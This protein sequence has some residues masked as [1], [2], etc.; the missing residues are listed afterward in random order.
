MMTKQL[1]RLFFFFFFF[2]LEE[3]ACLLLD[4]LIRRDICILTRARCIT[5]STFFRSDFRMFKVMRSS[6]R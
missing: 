5:I 4:R 1:A 3:L 6:L 2:K